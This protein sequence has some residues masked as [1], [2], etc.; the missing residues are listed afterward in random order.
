MDSRRGKDILSFVWLCLFLF[1]VCSLIWL[2][3]SITVLAADDYFYSTFWKNGWIGF[4]Q[5]NVEHYFTHNGRVMVHILASAMLKLGMRGFALINTGIL[6]AVCLLYLRLQQD[7]TCRPSFRMQAASLNL[8]FCF[9]LLIDFRVNKQVMMWVSGASNYIFPLLVAG[10]AALFCGGSYAPERKGWVCGLSVLFAFLA[11]A[12]TEQAGAF[13][14]ALVFCL[15]IYAQLRQKR[16][17]PLGLLQLLACLAGYLTIFLSPAT[18]GRMAAEFSV[19][20]LFFHLQQ[21]SVNF[22]APGRSLNL[23]VLFCAVVFVLRL[24]HKKLPKVLFLSGAV[25]LFLC[26]GFFV[27]PSV[28]LYVTMFTVFIAFV[29]LTVAVLVFWS[30]WAKSGF[31]LSAGLCSLL[32][33]L[34]TES[35]SV[36]VTFP[37]LLSM[38]LVC[39]HFCAL[40]YEALQPKHAT[41]LIVATG[42]FFLASVL[43]FLPTL[44]GCLKNHEIDLRNRQATETARTTGQFSY[45]DYDPYYSHTAMFESEYFESWFCRY[46]GLEDVEIHYTRETS[47]PI[48]VDGR[49]CTQPSVQSG[50]KSFFPARAVIE[51]LGGRMTWL[52]GDYLVFEYD[53]S[54]YTFSSPWIYGGGDRRYLARDGIFEFYDTIYISE[55]ILQEVFGIQI[56]RRENQLLVSS[57]L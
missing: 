38:I 55:D 15:W 30:P 19:E 14:M 1:F 49:Q 17:R 54:T 6:G 46:Y 8:F 5:R 20:A 36:R 53:G 31:L 16:W 40:I 11:G 7:Q 29:L 45:E 25:G 44:A 57:G 34:V 26:A 10:T 21:M 35:C 52:S 13:T 33:M 41:V 22:I 42:V 18:Q 27:V 3:Q 50:G 37:F 51:G 32:I 4:V 28:S 23:A 56:E 43:A 47:L 48:A 39:V 12:T 9:L 2:M 24:V